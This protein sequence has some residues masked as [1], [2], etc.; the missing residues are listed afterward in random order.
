MSYFCARSEKKRYLQIFAEMLNRRLHLWSRDKT[1][2]S[3]VNKNRQFLHSR[4]NQE[5]IFLNT[6]IPCKLILGKEG[7][8]IKIPLNK[9]LS[10]KE[11][12]YKWFLRKTC[13]A[14]STSW[15]PDFIFM[16]SQFKLRTF[17]FLKYGI[18]NYDSASWI[19]NFN[20]MNS[21]F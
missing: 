2:S 14:I 8:E 1:C 11:N 12:N 16:N 3:R 5:Y 13:R 21:R 10:K 18:H 19:H 20:F 17:P 6:V 9:I 15:I 7:L 4:W